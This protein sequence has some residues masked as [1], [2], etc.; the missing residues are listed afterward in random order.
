M[1]TSSSRGVLFQAFEW[2]LPDDGQHWRRVAAL[3][4]ELASRG[5]TAVWLPPPTKA[6]LGGLDTG[7]GVYDLWDLG[8]FDQKGSVR[9][10]YGTKDELV[11]CVRAVKGAGMDAYLDVVL[12]HRMGGDETEEVE[13]VE[14]AQ[15]DRHHAVTDPYVIRAWSHYTFPGRRGPDGAL[16]HSSF[17]WHWWHFTAFGANANAPDEH[18]KIFRVKDKAFADDVDGEYGNFDYLMG[19]DVDHAHDEVRAD[20]FAWGKWLVETTGCDGLRLDA[21]KH[22]PASFYRDWFGWLRSELP[23]REVFGVGEYWSASTDA[24]LGYLEA[25]GG[26]MR[27]FDVPLHFAFHRAGELGRDFDLRTIFDGSLVRAAPLAAVTFVDNHDSQPGQSLASPVADWFKPLAYA[28]IL[29]REEGYP[30]VFWGDYFGNDGARG[31][32]LTLVSHR[33]LVDVFLEVRAQYT[34]GDRHDWFDHPQCVGWVWTGDE[35]HPGTCAVL[36]STGD[37]GTKRMNL[38]APG[39]VLRDRTGHDPEAI[40]VGDDGWAELRCPPGSVSVWCTG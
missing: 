4:P 10:K 22:L 1:T 29:L 13:I 18:G 26:V 3:A 31:E 38:F 15:D 12:N 34:Y 37:A 17:E 25:S 7:Y 24:L 27:L 14:V 40:T 8:A 21:V 20:L 28:L 33:V 11:A 5:V 36:V 2:N 32:G 30:T 35:A 19:A 39:A 23:G 9:T 6:H 16:A